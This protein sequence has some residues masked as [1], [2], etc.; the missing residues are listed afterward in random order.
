MICEMKIKKIRTEF[1][2]SYELA[3]HWWKRIDMEAI[4]DNVKRVAEML[5]QAEIKVYEISLVKWL[6]WEPRP[7]GVREA[8]SGQ[9]WIPTQRTVDNYPPEE[10]GRVLRI[11]GDKG[12][13]VD[14]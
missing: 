4:G 2:L 10:S 5:Y 12:V 8:L 14:L 13:S 11:L 9:L 1:K 6:S 7:L 3:G